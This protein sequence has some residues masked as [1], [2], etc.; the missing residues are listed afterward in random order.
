[1]KSFLQH[2]KETSWNETPRIPPHKNQ[3]ISDEW[4][5]HKDTL[6]VR[7]TDP[8]G[9]TGVPIIKREPKF[10]R[11]ADHDGIIQTANGPENYKRGEHYIVQNGPQNFSVTLS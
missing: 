7:P 9:K 4:F 10:A 1:M 8:Y 6:T 5:D 2:L 11:L 3:G